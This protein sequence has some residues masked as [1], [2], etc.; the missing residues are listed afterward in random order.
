MI[1]SETSDSKKRGFLVPQIWCWCGWR[2]LRRRGFRRYRRERGG[3]Q[4]GW[5]SWGAIKVARCRRRRRERRLSAPARPRTSSSGEW[6]VVRIW[7]GTWKASSLFCFGSV[8][9]SALCS[10]TLLLRQQMQS[11]MRMCL[12]DIYGL[13]GQAIVG[14]YFNIKG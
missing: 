2:Q 14:Y 11:V 12:S 7:R 13:L 4:E 6:L 1:Q 9:E 8:E 10:A 5:A 3:R